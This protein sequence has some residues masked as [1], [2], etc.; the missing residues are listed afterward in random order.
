MPAQHSH[1]PR[2]QQQQ[3]SLLYYQAALLLAL[4]GQQLK[5]MVATVPLYCLAV[6]LPLSQHGLGPFRA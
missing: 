4:S 2:R 5:Q 1:P 3:D 6:H